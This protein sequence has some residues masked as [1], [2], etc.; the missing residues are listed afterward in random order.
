MAGIDKKGL[1]LFAPANRETNG[2]ALTPPPSKIEFWERTKKIT[3]P[4]RMAERAFF[5]IASAASG[6]SA[7]N[8]FDSGIG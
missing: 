7:S 4:R 1:A 8:L 3:P 5:M 6:L 2:L